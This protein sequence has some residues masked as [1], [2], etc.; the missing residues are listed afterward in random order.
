[1]ASVLR[2]LDRVLNSDFCPQ[3]N[4][5]VYWMKEPF[6][7][8][9]IALMLSLAVG[10]WVNPAAFLVSGLLVLTGLVGAG[11]PRLSIGGLD[12]E[13]IFDQL[14]GRAG[15]PLLV[16]LRIV[17]RRPW[18]AWGLSLIRGFQGESCLSSG[19]L[20]G[21]DSV[22][23]P[24]VSLGR[25]PGWSQ[26]EFSWRFV[27][28]VH[29]AYPLEAPELETGFPFGMFAARQS[30]RRHGVAV[31]WP[32]AGH[33]PGVPGS[34]SVHVHDDSVTSLRPGNAGDLLGTRPFRRGDSLRRVHWI[35][36]ARQQQ[37][38]AT[39]RQTQ[40]R[41]R[42]VLHLDTAVASHAVA[43]GGRNGVGRSATLL[44]STLVAGRICESLHRQGCDLELRAG[45][46][47]LPA[48]GGV[49]GFC[50]QMDAISGA[51][52]EC[53]GGELSEG[54]VGGGRAGELALLVTTAGAI[55]A[56]PQLLRKFRVIC[57]SV[58]EGELSADVAAGVWISVSGW[59]GVEFEL[60]E[61]WREVCHER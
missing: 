12:C 18:P 40:T 51:T 21:G 48:G 11:W 34:V 33:L 42:V 6:W 35:Q 17:N 24:G 44:L 16:R 15:E 28:R 45:R 52:V 8:L 39:E 49:V 29:G 9:V 61:R 38:I 57:V 47:V 55:M 31:V 7:C 58:E 5:F 36:T 20:A 25:I 41:S 23:S 14:R 10:L 50:R 3:L 32:S 46:L 26:V 13:L 43:G 1:M 59:R 53:I 30:V 19:G 22:I 27:P 54:I 56:Q 37:L 2:W 4:R 60:S